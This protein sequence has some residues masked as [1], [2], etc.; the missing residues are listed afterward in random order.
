MYSVIVHVKGATP[1]SYE[2]LEDDRHAARERAEEIA[3][4]GFWIDNSNPSRFIPASC[5][6]LINVKRQCVSGAKQP[7]R[8]QS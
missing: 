1:A 3:R 7:R 6:E 2:F 4:E 5:I 8:R